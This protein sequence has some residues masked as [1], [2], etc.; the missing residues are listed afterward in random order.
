MS[1]LVRAAKGIPGLTTYHSA[2][3]RF[4][5]GGLISGG[6]W[7]FRRRSVRV[8]NWG[9]LI[10]RGALGGAAVMLYFYAISEIGLAKG[11]VLS[12]TYPLWAGLLAPLVIHE[13]LRVGFIGAVACALGGLYLMVVPRG[14]F[15]GVSWQDLA[16]LSGG[17]LG[18]IALL[19]VKRLRETDSSLVIYLSQCF[20]G[21]LMVAYPA[22]R[23]AVD[24]ALPGWALL[25]GIGLLAT[26]GQLLM[27]YVFKHVG[28]TEGAL[29]TMLTPVGNVFL[30]VLVFREAL[31][32][33][34]IA[35]GTM[36]LAACAYAALP[37]RRA[38]GHPA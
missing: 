4:L 6:V 32:V 22:S 1:L 21:L 20:F 31:T 12:F 24:F 15:A 23:N 18:G 37:A 3:F 17:L 27:T 8:V 28:G 36:V 2:L 30:G 35:G 26:A 10:A 38:P 34:M 7:W 29:L 16:A 11:T 5:L 19:A 13:R 9:W 14:S 33:R 25:L